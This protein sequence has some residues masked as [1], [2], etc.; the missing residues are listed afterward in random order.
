[1]ALNGLGNIA[2]SQSDYACAHA[3]YVRYLEISEAHGHPLDICTALRN[4]SMVTRKLGDND[5][6]TLYAE[7]CIALCRAIGFQRCLA[8]GLAQMGTLAF[9]QDDFFKAQDYFQ[10]SLN[11]SRLISHHANEASVLS[12]LGS[13]L[14][15]LGD[16]PASLE[17]L[18]MALSVSIRIGDRWASAIALRYMTDV[19]RVIGDIPH[20]CLKLRQGLEIAC[21]LQSNAIRVKYLLEAALLWCDQDRAEQAAI[22]IGLLQENANLLTTEEIKLYHQLIRRLEG[23]LSQEQF[24]AANE[25]GKTLNLDTVMQE[26][27]QE[28][29][30]A[31]RA[32]TDSLVTRFTLLF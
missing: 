6:A 2:W 20:A 22:W 8:E 28:L 32:T 12:E 21:R 3:Y 10:E 7:R 15:E 11:V 1:M 5:R 30:N 31:R 14:C 17:Y 18:E 25:R 24:S 4:L 23:R 27:L 9:R 16:M 13:L 19:F 26:I 29:S